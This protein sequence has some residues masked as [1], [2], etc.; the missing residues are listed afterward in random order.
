MEDSTFRKQKSTD[1]FF[2][3]FRQKNVSN[4][5]HQSDRSDMQHCTK[6][7]F[8]SVKNTTKLC[9]EGAIGNLMNLFHCNEIEVNQF[10]SIVQSP[11]N[12]IQ[13]NLGESAVP[14]AVQKKLDSE[15]DSININLWILCKKFKFSTTSLLQIERFK[16]LN[17]AIK[18]LTEI[19]FPLI[20]SVMGTHAC[21]HHVVVVWRGMII[22]YDSEY[23]F[24]LT[25]NSLRQ[26]C[27][28]NTS[29]AKISCGYGI[30]PP[31]NIQNSM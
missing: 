7:K 13:K 18:I 17:N 19:K 5:Q 9:A 22:D 28:V 6:N 25:N 16:N 15:C 11:I 4:K 1:F 8:F 31:K 12:L 24:S 29:Y 2:S 27:G 3:H 23:T 26:I 14:K 10:W 30:F 21:Y 20:I